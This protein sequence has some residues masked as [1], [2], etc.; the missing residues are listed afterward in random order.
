MKREKA[1]NSKNVQILF[2]YN[3]EVICHG[4]CADPKKSLFKGKQEA[5]STVVNFT[6]QGNTALLTL[7]HVGVMHQGK[8]W[9]LETFTVFTQ[10]ED[11]DLLCHSSTVYC[12]GLC[13]FNVYSDSHNF[14]LTTL[15][16][17]ILFC[18]FILAIIVYRQMTCFPKIFQYIWRKSINP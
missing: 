6:V 5:K 18:N 2:N 17:L 14:C 9:G 13:C 15:G 7:Q 4:C 12:L 1:K 16:L 11:D 3:I 10:L 8:V